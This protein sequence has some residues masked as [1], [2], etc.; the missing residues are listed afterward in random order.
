[1]QKIRFDEAVNRIRRSDQR[2]EPDGYA[3]LRDALD[4][5]VKSLQIDEM[6]EHRHVSGPELL[7]GLR[8]FA[9]RDFGP[10][11]MTVLAHWGIRTGE[12]IG[13]MVFQLIEVGAFGKSAEDT[14]EDFHDV[15]DLEEELRAP[16]RPTRKPRLIPM[17]GDLAGKEV[18][19]TGE[20]ALKT[21]GSRFEAAENTGEA[22][23]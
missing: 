3:F 2:F 23:R 5:T 15:F 6:E 22:F 19:T 18:E 17:L 9:L 10:M 4:Y 14:L 21:E 12:D 1:M 20:E 13:A 16:F 8:D 7:F 11:A